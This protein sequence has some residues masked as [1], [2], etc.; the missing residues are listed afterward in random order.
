MYTKILHACLY[1]Y[2]SVCVR[3]H[4]CVLD[5]RVCVYVCGNYNTQM[6]WN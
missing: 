5:V 2:N 3:V 1:K 4:V 6:E